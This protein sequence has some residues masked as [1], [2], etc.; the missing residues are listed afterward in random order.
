MLLKGIDPASAILVQAR[1][2]LVYIDMESDAKLA[3]L[4]PEVRAL[5]E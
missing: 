3:D 2:G 4:P 5:F 1:P